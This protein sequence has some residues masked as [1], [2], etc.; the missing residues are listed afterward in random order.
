MPKELV[1]CFLLTFFCFQL[2]FLL[3]AGSSGHC[4]RLR[5]KSESGPRSTCKHCLPPWSRARGNRAA[6]RHFLILCGLSGAWAQTEVR[7]KSVALESTLLL[8]GKVNRTAQ[9]WVCLQ[10]Q[11]LRH[12]NNKTTTTSETPQL[13]W[14]S[15]ASDSTL[16][17][18]YANYLLRTQCSFFQYILFQRQYFSS[19]LLPIIFLKKIVIFWKPVFCIFL[20]LSLFLLFLSS[21]SSWKRTEKFLQ[22]GYL[23]YFS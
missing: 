19:L 14:D 3:P 20:N 6:R 10:S 4:F 16:K 18:P 1:L 11:M 23:L 2:I 13:M 9:F 5:G 22:D 17:G 21:F 15:Y 12:S 8:G 7:F